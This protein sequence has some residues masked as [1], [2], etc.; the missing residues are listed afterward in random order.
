MPK[1]TPE[2]LNALAEQYGISPEELTNL[3]NNT[4]N[5]AN[6]IILQLNHLPNWMAS[7]ILAQALV[8]IIKPDGIPKEKLLSFVGEVYDATDEFYSVHNGKA[9]PKQ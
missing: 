3:G 8:G 2:Q 7:A 9:I 5:T 4:T 1:A 6:R